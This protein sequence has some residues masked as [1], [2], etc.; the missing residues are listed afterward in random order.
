MYVRI[1]FTHKVVPERRILGLISLVILTVVSMLIE[2]GTCKLV[3]TSLASYDYCNVEFVLMYVKEESI[4]D[5]LI[6]I[7]IPTA[8][9]KS[10]VNGERLTARHMYPHVDMAPYTKEFRVSVNEIGNVIVHDNGN[11]M[12]V[13]WAFKLSMLFG[14]S[15]IF[16]WKHYLEDD[17]DELKYYVKTC[18]EN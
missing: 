13:L 9:Y 8:T 12:H 6:P 4:L 14:I 18:D 10:Y 11:L 3:K 1:P 17:P 7:K 2:I 16:T 5:G 15:C